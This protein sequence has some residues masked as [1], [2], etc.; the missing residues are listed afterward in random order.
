MINIK[1]LYFSY[2]ANKIFENI[3][4]NIYRKDKIGLV[5]IN[6]SGKTTFLKLLSGELKPDKGEIIFEGNVKVGYIPQELNFDDNETP[7]K[8]CRKAFEEENDLIKKFEKISNNFANNS[9]LAEEYD[10]IL[11]LI[12]QKNAFNIDYKIEN[13]LFNLGFNKETINKNLVNLS[14]GYKIRAYIGFLLLL[15]KD[16][17]LLD[18]PTNYLDIDSII[19]LTEYLKSFQKSFI[20][21]SHDINFLDSVVNKIFYL[22]NQKIFEFN[23]CNYTKFIEK[24]KEMVE[25]INKINEN[26]LKE[27]EH[28]Q[29]F[30]DRF[31]AKNTI[32]KRVQSKIKSIEKLQKEITDLNL[33]ENKISFFINNND[34]RFLNILSFENVDFS[35]NS[36]LDKEDLIFENI[37]FSITRGEKILLLGKNGVGK[38]TLLK[39]AS[40]KLKP[41]KGRIIYHN[42]ASYGYFSQD[43]T[44]SLNYENDVI[45]EFEKENV[46]LNMKD[47][48]K[49]TYLGIFGFEKDDIY[50]KIKFLSGGEKVRLLIAKIFVNSPDILLLDEPTTYLDINSKDI[51]AQCIIN[52]NGAVI[53]VSHDIDFIKKTASILWTIENRKIK[54]LKNLDEYLD[55]KKIELVSKYDRENK[56]KIGFNNFKN[57]DNK[58]KKD[59]YKKRVNEKRKI[60]IENDILKIENRIKEI[61]KRF[62]VENWKKEHI[63]LKNEYEELKDKLKKLEEEWFNL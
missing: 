28:L 19:F 41:I 27:I 49:R 32:A 48:E 4:L 51:L 25:Q 10:K 13:I 59:D 47:K 31:R 11:H 37:S 9:N 14:G 38:T 3:N 24:K 57:N 8:L 61:E 12:E 17:L 21:I 23:G 26:K 46:S 22:N 39:L 16:L 18:E 33:K 58:R 2:G 54:V 44:E 7:L 6:G 15:D 52:F 5:G 62:L 63:F 43:I 1:N 36:I 42:K 60:E 56:E 29:E 30:V 53:L 40:N 34:N 45:T 55:R 20:V 50:K 35:Y